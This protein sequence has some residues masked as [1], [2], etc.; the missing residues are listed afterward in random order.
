MSDP[1]VVCLMFTHPL[2][3]TVHQK[4]VISLSIVVIVVAVVLVSSRWKLRWLLVSR[5]T[6]VVSR[7]TILVS[8]DIIFGSR[9][10][11]VGRILGVHTMCRLMRQ[12]GPDITLIILGDIHRGI[13]GTMVRFRGVVRGVGGVKVR[14]TRHVTIVGDRIGYTTKA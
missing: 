11:I 13:G 8:R 14:V 6:I 10:M 4:I 5:Q 12:N 1:E 2:V 3:K 7:D 9:Y